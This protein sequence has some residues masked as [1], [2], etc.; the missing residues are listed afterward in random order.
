VFR[1]SI[2]AEIGVLQPEVGAAMDFDF[3]FRAAAQR[4]FVLRHELGAIFSRSSPFVPDRLWSRVDGLWPGWRKLMSNLVNNPQI[5]SRVRQD[6]RPL[7]D[8]MLAEFLWIAAC[9]A[10]LRGE[11]EEA[12]KAAELLRTELGK[13]I[14]RTVIRGLVRIFR[15]LPI[16]RNFARGVIT[17]RAIW[18]RLREGMGDRYGKYRTVLEVEAQR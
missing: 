12:N 11:Y 8:E 16:S 10:L 9:S 2:I 15:S 6:L 5:P 18:R 17:L 1:T 3:E 7:L 14:R 13:D 4:P